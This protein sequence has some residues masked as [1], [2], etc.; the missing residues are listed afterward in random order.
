MSLILLDGDQDKH[1]DT[2]DVE[3][4]EQ[5]TLDDLYMVFHQS[6]FNVI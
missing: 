4:V 2:Q 1:V 6:Q 5:V 3:W